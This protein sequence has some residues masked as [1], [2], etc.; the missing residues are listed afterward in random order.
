MDSLHFLLNIQPPNSRI[1]IKSKEKITFKC[2]FLQALYNAVCPYLFF[3]FKRCSGSFV[4]TKYLIIEILK[5]HFFILLFI[6][7][8]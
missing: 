7:F 6:I 1:L 4:E 3:L 5:K 2:P 8:R